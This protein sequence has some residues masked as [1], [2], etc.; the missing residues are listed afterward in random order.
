MADHHFV[1]RAT[2]TEDGHE[3]KAMTYPETWDRAQTFWSRFDDARR[4]LGV[5]MHQQHH[6]VRSVADPAYAHLLY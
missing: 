3:F 5:S 1:I 2:R 4:R 6:M